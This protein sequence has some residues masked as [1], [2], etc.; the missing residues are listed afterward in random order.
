MATFFAVL[1]RRHD[2]R[3]RGWPDLCHAAGTGDFVSE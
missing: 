1:K 2:R 3:A